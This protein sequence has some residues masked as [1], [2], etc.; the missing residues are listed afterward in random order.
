VLDGYRKYLPGKW[1]K[2]VPIVPVVRLHGVIGQTSPFRT[3]LTLSSVAQSLERAF[4][5]KRAPAV[6]LI[7]NSPG[8][9][10][11]Q[12]RLIY[13]RIRALAEE[14]SKEVLVFIEDVA[15]SGGYMIAIAGDE[16]IADPSSIVGSIGVV[17]PGSASPG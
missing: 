9:S 10:P 11:V 13:T 5:I 12:A 17:F 14:H 7:V 6:A 8:G 4:S 2:S 3:G 1:G 15:A 16:I